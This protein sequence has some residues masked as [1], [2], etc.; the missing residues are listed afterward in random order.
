MEDKKVGIIYSFYDETGKYIAIVH[1]NTPKET[2]ERLKQKY[3]EVRY[4]EQ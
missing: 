2:I 1:E 4:K 3:N